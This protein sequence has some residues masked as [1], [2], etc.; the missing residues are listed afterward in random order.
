[1]TIAQITGEYFPV[2]EGFDR[3]IRVSNIIRRIKSKC[4]HYEL[5]WTI[6]GTGGGRGG[7]TVWRAKK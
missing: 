4:H 6:D 1:M 2:G 7:R 3:G 5:D